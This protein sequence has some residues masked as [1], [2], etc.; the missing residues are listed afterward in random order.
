MIF[1]STSVYDLFWYNSLINIHIPKQL[2][3]LP[4]VHLKMI[5]LICISKIINT[6]VFENQV[7]NMKSI[8]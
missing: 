2:Q 1:T 7:N 5:A 6:C 8:T 4:V 3:Q